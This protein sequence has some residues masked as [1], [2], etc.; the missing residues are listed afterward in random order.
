MPASH[1]AIAAALL[2]SLLI[3]SVSA[4]DE[5]PPTPSRSQLLAKSSPVEWRTPNP[6]NLLVMQLP[7][8]RVLI[9]LAPEQPRGQRQE[10]ARHDPAQPR[11]QRTRA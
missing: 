10:R 7:T 11:E 8:G 1:R 6:D 3:G 2:A 5:Q 4:A 9:E